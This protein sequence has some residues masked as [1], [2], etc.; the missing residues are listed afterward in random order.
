[1]WPGVRVHGRARIAHGVRGSTSLDA[2]TRPESLRDSE[3]ELLLFALTPPRSSTAP[4]KV[5]E[6]AER[7][8]ARL[9][10]LDLDGLILYDIDDESDRNAD[11]RPFPFARTLDPSDYLRDHLS[12]ALARWDIPAV[13]YRAV[14]KYAPDELGRWL[15]DQDA[16]RVASVL[17]GA[18]SHHKPVR[19]SLADAQVLAAER[20]P[21]LVRG[22]VAL[23]ERHTRRGD[24]H[25]RLLAKQH[26]GCSFF[27]TQVVYDTNAAKNMV[28][29]YH[30]ECLVRGVQ[31]ARIVFT[32]TLCGSMKTL[33]FLQWLGVDVPRWI[34]NELSN[35]DDTLE[36]S[37]EQALATCRDLIGFCRRLGVPF[38]I[39]V[40]SVSVRRAEIEAS[41]QL[42]AAL[43][44][45]LH[46]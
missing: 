17:V 6:V 25:L 10:P 41:V 15:D 37:Y 34:G 40:E 38:G 24:E 12:P 29:D 20:R 7:T 13:V 39:N 27:V 45:D 8:I 11:E 4:E 22:A 31:P 30:Y 42:A 43:Q 9:E 33:E 32:I 1:M 44:D 5:A 26:E 28:S 46:R 18:S 2:V 16:G 23:P 36:T 19:T 14:G 35:A 21:D 3:G